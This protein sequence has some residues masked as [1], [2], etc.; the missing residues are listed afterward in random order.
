MTI[1]EEIKSKLQE[2]AFFINEDAKNIRIEASKLAK[3]FEDKF[4]NPTVPINIDD[5]DQRYL[6]KNQMYYLND[7]RSEEGLQTNCRDRR[8]TSG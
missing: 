7:F 5:M 2:I 3:E 8:S 4:S 6:K 1:T